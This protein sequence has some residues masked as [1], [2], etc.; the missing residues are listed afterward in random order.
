MDIVVAQGKKQYS[1]TLR[2]NALH[3][4][5]DLTGFFDEEKDYS[6]S[7]LSEQCKV[8]E[9]RTYISIPAEVAEE[10]RDKLRE[11]TKVQIGI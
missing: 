5:L 11:Q 3:I 9:K 10:A 6:W 7:A 8:K 4:T 2:S 1:F